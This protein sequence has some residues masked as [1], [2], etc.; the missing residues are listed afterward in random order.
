HAAGP[1]AAVA[2]HEDGRTLDVHPPDLLVSVRPAQPRH[3]DVEDQ[4]INPAGSRDEDFVPE[5]AEDVARDL[6][7][8]LVVLGDQD[9]FGPAPQL[10]FRLRRFGDDLLFG[11]G[12]EDFEGGPVPDLAVDVNQRVVL[13]DDA[14]DDREAE[15]GPVAGPLRGEER[16]EDV[17]LR[18]LTHAAARVADAQL[19][20]PAVPRPRVYPAERLVER[21]VGGFND[22]L[23]PER[24][25]VA[26][27]DGEV[28]NHLLDLHR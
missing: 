28:H 15:A 25:R 12:E 19:H 20:E 26:G 9:G 21:D 23:P 27:V 14:V 16:L 24:H 11:D 22:Q 5:F 3:D 6:A 4:Q 8:R 7:Q 1:L 18:F 17:L 10:V 2:R 13:P